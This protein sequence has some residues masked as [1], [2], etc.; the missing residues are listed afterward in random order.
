M[1]DL[2][3]HVFAVGP[4]RRGCGFARG[5]NSPNE[6]KGEPAAFASVLETVANFCETNP[7]TIYAGFAGG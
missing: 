4:G 5:G 7:T 3:D 2:R 1:R 6:P